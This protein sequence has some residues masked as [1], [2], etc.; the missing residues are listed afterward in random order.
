VYFLELQFVVEV[1]DDNLESSPPMRLDSIAA[2]LRRYLV[3]TLASLLL[4]PA[5]I[6]FTTNLLEFIYPSAMHFKKCQC[7]QG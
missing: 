6:L 4:S 3:L 2:L 5:T 7:V 1:S